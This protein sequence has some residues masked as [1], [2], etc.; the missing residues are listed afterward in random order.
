MNIVYNPKESELI[1][2]MGKALQFMLDF[3]GYQEKCRECDFK[4]A[5]YN[6]FKISGEFVSIG[7]GEN[8]SKRQT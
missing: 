2:D 8:E 6:L 3:C 1:G 7:D 5:C 4:N